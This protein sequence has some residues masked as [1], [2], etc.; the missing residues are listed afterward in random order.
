MSS[1]LDSTLLVIDIETTCWDYWEKPADEVQDIIEIGLCLLCI[2]TDIP[3][4]S[5]KRSILI[6]PGRSKVS[7][8]C[9]S[10]TS[11][12]QEMLDK[13]GIHL[14]TAFDILRKEYKS[15]FRTWCSWG[16]FDRN[17]IERT[18]VPFRLDYPLGRRHINLK[19]LYSVMKHLPRELGL[20]SALEREG[21]PLEGRHHRGHDDAWNIAKIAQRMFSK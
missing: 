19:N 11:I 1:K 14:P 8:F 21:I 16:D 6:K 5:D 13:E 18:C 7:K 4:I 10:L 12:T 9:T 3:T 17:M 2:D 15:E 20:D